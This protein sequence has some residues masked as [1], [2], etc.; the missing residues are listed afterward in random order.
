[1]RLS[2][3]LFTASAAVLLAACNPA[4][5]KRSDSDPIA[6]EA[7]PH[8]QLPD[9]VTPESYRVDMVIDPQEEGMSGT[10]AIDLVVNEAADEIWIHAKEMSVSSGTEAC[11]RNESSYCAIRV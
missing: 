4:T 5:D 1:M 9:T 3:F 11:I 6:L 8:A 10:V 2:K 7:I